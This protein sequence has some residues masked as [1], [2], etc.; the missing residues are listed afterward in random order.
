MPGAEGATHFKATSHTQEDAV[1]NP[2]SSR[3]ALPVVCISSFIHLI[4]QLTLILTLRL[5]PFF[6]E[7]L[8]HFYLQK[9]SFALRLQLPTTVELPHYTLPPFLQMVFSGG[10]WQ[11]F[12][13]PVLPTPHVYYLH[14]FFQ[15]LKEV[16][17]G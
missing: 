14:L 11:H 12:F 15:R 13:K 8:P 5:K 9:L 3:V 16:T 10:W 4:V 17:M 1:F 2:S 7:E 6:E